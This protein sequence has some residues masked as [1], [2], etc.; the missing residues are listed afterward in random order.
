MH[1]WTMDA[2]VGGWVILPD[3]SVVLT[4]YHARPEFVGGLES[5][6]VESGVVVVWQIKRCLFR[7]AEYRDPSRS[8]GV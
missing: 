4:L 2:S 7:E 8:R 3:A 5:S 1:P 6:L